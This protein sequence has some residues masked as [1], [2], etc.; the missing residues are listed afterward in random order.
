[1]NANDIR[2]DDV[3]AYIS[4]T[5][6]ENMRQITD[7]VRGRFEADQHAAKASFRVGDRVRFEVKRHGARRVVFGVVT[8]KKVKRVEVRPDGGGPNWRVSP[9]LLQKAP[10]ADQA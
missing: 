8:A 4:K 10:A 1:M 3:L 7:A 6:R 2:L 5:S 9:T